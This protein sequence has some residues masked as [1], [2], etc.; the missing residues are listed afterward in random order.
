MPT[1][2]ITINGSRVDIRNNLI[3]TF[4]NELPGT[5]KGPNRSIYEFIKITQ[6]NIP[7]FFRPESSSLGLKNNLN[8][9]SKIL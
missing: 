3:M 4:L 9:F 8:N 7:D 6:Q 5:G 2:T 1:I